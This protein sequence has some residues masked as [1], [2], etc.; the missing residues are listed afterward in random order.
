MCVVCKL[1]VQQT[2][3]PLEILGAFPK[4]AKNDY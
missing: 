3:I 4:I 1:Q 2:S